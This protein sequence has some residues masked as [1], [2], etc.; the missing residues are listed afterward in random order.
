MRLDLFP[1]NTVL[2]PRLRLPLH[3]SEPRYR[4]MIRRCLDQDLRCGVVLVKEGEEVGDR[5]VPHEVGT[6]ARVLQAETSTDGRLNIVL[7]GKQRF[8]IESIVQDRPHVVGEVSLD[9]MPMRDPRGV[10]AAAFE[11]RNAFRRVLALMLELQAGYA[12]QLDLPRDP[13]RLAYF[14]AAGLAIENP[15]RQRLLESASVDALLDEERRMVDH[16]IGA[17]ERRLAEHWERRRN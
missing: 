7:V 11:T 16:H 3:I 15:T 14:V 1:L 17:L 2:F 12:P 10:A 6:T 9:P 13:E 8:R 5:V 4:T